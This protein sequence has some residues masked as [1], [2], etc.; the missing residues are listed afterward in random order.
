MTKQEEMGR[1]IVRDSILIHRPTVRFL[2]DDV[3]CRAILENNEHFEMMHDPMLM[4]T[5]VS[6][7]NKPRDMLVYGISWEEIDG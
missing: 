4:G 6:C 2:T 3:L 7:Q 5:V 1:F